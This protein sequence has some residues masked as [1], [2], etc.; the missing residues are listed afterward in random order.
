MSIATMT[1]EQVDRLGDEFAADL[2]RRIAEL[3]PPSNPARDRRLRRAKRDLEYFA[4]TYLPH[5]CEAPFADFHREDWRRSRAAEPVC[6]D[7][8]LAAPREHAKTT[9]CGIIPVMHRILFGR[10]RFVLWCSETDE[11]ASRRVLQLRRELEDNKAIRRD[12][13]DLRGFPWR[14]DLF[15][16]ATGASVGGIGRLSQVRGICDAAGERPTLVVL[17]DIEDGADYKNP[18]NVAAVADWLEEKV[19]NSLARGG[20]I[21]WRGTIVHERCL[22]KRYLDEE[23]LPCAMHRADGDDGAALWPEWWPRERLDAQRQKI[24]SARYEKEFN[25]RPIDP[26]VQDFRLEMFPFFDPAEIPDDWPRYGGVDPAISQSRKAARFALADI[27][28]GPREVCVMDMVLK[29]LT[30]RQQVLRLLDYDRRVQPIATGV[31]AVAY[32][33]ALAEQVADEGDAQQLWPAVKPVPAIGPKLERILS[34]QPMAER[35]AIRFAEHLRPVVE[36]MCLFPH[37]GLDAWDALYHA[38]RIAKRT[39][40]IEYR[41]TREKNLAGRLAAY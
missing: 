9:A 27:A 26:A 21:W 31:E 25:Q 28:V 40:P 33:R 7:D 13:G 37:A 6:G 10:E 16:T 35:R 1:P 24:G 15:T 17:D 36:E 19:I 39:G 23:R 11:V 29:R 20:R 32:Q 38:I 22:L 8:L 34:L 12:F 18:A 3:A 2:D 41:S 5:L 30:F 4:R 14:A